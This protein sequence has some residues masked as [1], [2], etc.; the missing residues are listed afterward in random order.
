MN[1]LQST[2]PPLAWTL[3]AAAAIISSVVLA[4]C[5]VAVSGLTTV[6]L[7]VTVGAFETFSCADLATKVYH[8]LIDNYGD[9]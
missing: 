4:C 8:W 3:A 1:E 6:M 2:W 5:P 9:A 7:A